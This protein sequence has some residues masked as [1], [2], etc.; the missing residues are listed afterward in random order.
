MWFRYKCHLEG[1]YIFKGVLNAS[2]YYEVVE[3]VQR[4]YGNK[5]EVREIEKVE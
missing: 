1:K 5:Y 2:D 3:S 4:M